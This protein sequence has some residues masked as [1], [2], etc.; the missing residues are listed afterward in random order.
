MNLNT[1]I[2]IGKIQLSLQNSMI[3]QDGN[4][5]EVLLLLKEW[6]MLDG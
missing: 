1:K 6:V 5:E 2:L 4:V 3:S